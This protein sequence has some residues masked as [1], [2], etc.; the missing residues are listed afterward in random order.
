MVETRSWRIVKFLKR[1]KDVRLVSSP[2]VL[3]RSGKP[4]NISIGTWTR[5]DADE[6]F[7]LEFT[8]EATAGVGVVKY[9]MTIGFKAPLELGA[10]RKAGQ[11]ESRVSYSSSVNPGQTAWLVVPNIDGTKR[12]IIVKQFRVH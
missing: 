7:S 4:A 5:V 2:F 1:H 10:G 12:L 3:T 8:P 9:D 11:R 6:A